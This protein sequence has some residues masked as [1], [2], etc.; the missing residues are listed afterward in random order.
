MTDASLKR[1]SKTKK[2]GHGKGRL[3]VLSYIQMYT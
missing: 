1:A 2:D 3:N